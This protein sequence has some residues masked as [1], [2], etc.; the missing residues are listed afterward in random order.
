MTSNLLKSMG[1]ANID[2]GIVLL[3]MIAVLLILSILLVIQMIQ[4]NKYKKKYNKFM[5]GKNAKSLEKDI[6]ALYEDNIFIKNNVEKN[7]MDIQELFDKHQYAFQKMGLI[8]YDAFKEMGG[9]LS[10]TLALLNEKNDGFVINSVHSSDGC[11]SYTKKI[12]NGES[13][14]DLSNEEKEAVERAINSV[15]VKTKVE[16]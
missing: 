9:K 4:F 3:V 5:Q 8:K 2:I 6:I 15:K 1:L 16:E 12:K 13:N 7:Q 10:F 11:Y 14:I